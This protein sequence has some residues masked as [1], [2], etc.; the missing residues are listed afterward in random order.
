MV[1]AATGRRQGAWRARRVLVARQARLSR[2]LPAPAAAAR[3]RPW[4]QSEEFLSAWDVA[5]LS[6]VN[7]TPAQYELLHFLD[8]TDLEIDRAVAFDVAYPGHG[9]LQYSAGQ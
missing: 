4:P 1:G 3:A 7:L 2:R 8:L 9:P 6:V 5:L